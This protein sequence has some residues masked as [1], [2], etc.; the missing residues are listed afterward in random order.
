MVSE[1]LNLEEM[2]SAQANKFVTFNRDLRQIEAM[3]V[4]VLSRTNGGPPVSPAAGATYIIDAATGAWSTSAVNRIAHF[5][6]GVWRFY[7]VVEG[8]RVWVNNENI[9][10]VY[11]GTSW[12]AQA[13]GDTGIAALTNNSV[14]FASGDIVI[15]DINFNYNPTTDTL[16]T[17]N[18][19]SGTGNFGSGRVNSSYVPTVGADLTNKTYTDTK[20]AL[21]GGTITGQTIINSNVADAILQLNSTAA[22][23]SDVLRVS[24]NLS[25]LRII[26]TGLTLGFFGI[27]LNTDD[28][29]ADFTYSN[30]TG[31]NRIGGLQS[32][33]F[34]TLFSGGVERVRID[35]SGNVGIG[36]TSPGQKLDVVGSI[37]S[38]GPIF[39]GRYT[40]TNK[41][42]LSVAAGAQVYD[43]T[44]NRMSYYNGTAW[45]NY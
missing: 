21:T 41:L 37:K 27:T 11:N 9:V 12:V 13:S 22:A 15:E 10:V 6:L 28:P 19:I 35:T 30:D 33:V 23:D 2:T 26:D 43:T 31:E 45:V 7:P 36:T 29:V 25:K 8:V 20:L 24:G 5:S 42:A 1:I 16:S 4:R 32:Y 3:T 17:P 44:L 40:T 34:M 14:P 39:P 18:L 38:S